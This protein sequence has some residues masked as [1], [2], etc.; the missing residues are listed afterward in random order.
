[1]GRIR[2][3]LD[4]A[5][6]NVIARV[7]L[8]VFFRH[9][10]VVGAENVP[11]SG[12]VLVVANHVNNLIDPM[13]LLAFRGRT[14]RFLAKSTLWAH[15]VVMPLLALAGALPVYRK[16]D[17]ED[18]RRN[19]ETFDRALRELSA[20]GAVA[21]FP[22]GRSHNEPGSLPLKTG[23]TPLKTGAARIALEAT[24]APQRLPLRVLPVGLVYEEKERFRS[25]VLVLVGRPLEVAEE[26][27]LYERAP[28]EAVRV[29]THRLYGALAELVPPFSSWEQARL[30]DA[31][32]EAVAGE[33]AA[34]LPLSERW[35]LWRRFASR[36]RALRDVD[37][38]R[39]G[40]LVEAVR[41][42]ETTRGTAWNRV[43]TVGSPL[44]RP[45]RW[46]PG[47][48]LVLWPI[49]AIGFVLN[50]LPFQLPGWIA[51]RFTRTPDEPATYK[52]LSA[53][54]VFPA[55][56]ALEALV[57]GLLAGPLAALAVALIAP[58]SG[59]LALLIYESRPQRALAPPP[60]DLEPTR[61]ALRQEILS[62]LDR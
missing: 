52:I 44:R 13:L 1:M 22:E 47:A 48:G 40:L 41:R 24:A 58:V 42:F 32:V 11:A 9:I 27:D 20:G 33:E 16:Q 17:G 36:H 10:E 34:V 43:R 62:L 8:G 38:D 25:R 45:R 4:A 2:R 57:A 46:P 53:L 51:R 60:P 55:V 59:Y 7:T 35:T 28:R 12:P 50:V 31:A 15:P 26:A 23:A 21:I 54:L 29:L 37:P 18:V 56:W 14:P 19:R 5:V 30:V 39:A 6:V 3:I 49:H 61:I